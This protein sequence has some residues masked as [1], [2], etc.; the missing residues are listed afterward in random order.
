MESCISD[1]IGSFAKIWVGFNY[2]FET[3]DVDLTVVDK[4]VIDI[5]KLDPPFFLQLDPTYSGRSEGHAKF[6]MRRRLLSKSPALYFHD[7]NDILWVG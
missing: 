6:L 3:A 4:E 5:E 7:Q 2:T 1:M